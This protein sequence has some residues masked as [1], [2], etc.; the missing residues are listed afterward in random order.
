M[1]RTSTIIVNFV[2]LQRRKNTAPI[3]IKL[4]MVCND[5]SLVNESL[6]RWQAEQPRMQKYRQR[7]AIIYFARIELSHL[8]EGLKVVL[9][10][11][12]F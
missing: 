6:V 3:V 10:F 12:H 5:L 1:S 4:M 11:A 7:G 9:R 2:Q 8:F